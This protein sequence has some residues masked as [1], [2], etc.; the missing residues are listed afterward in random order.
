M[1]INSFN[2]LGWWAAVLF[3][4]VLGLNVIAKDKDPNMI[5]QGKVFLIDKDSSII[6][7][8]T[9]TGVRRLVVYSPDTKFRY[10]RSDKGQESAIGQV[11]NTQYI[12]CIG[13]SDD[14][15]RL[16]AKE[17]VHRWQK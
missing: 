3:Y 10:G 6:M 2:A 17:C 9:I 11:Q 8:D 12:S 1:R 7:V 14:G 15:A 5:V 13:K 4:L 16:L